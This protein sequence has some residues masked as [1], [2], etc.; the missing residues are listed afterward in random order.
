[1]PSA[2][3]KSV[4]ED[5]GNE[6]RANTSFERFFKKK[7]LVKIRTV[8]NIIE[9]RKTIEKTNKAKSWL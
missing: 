5:I 4:G 2:C 9:N 3:L 1:M 6:R 8:I 7:A